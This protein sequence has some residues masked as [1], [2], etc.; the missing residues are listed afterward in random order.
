MI[1]YIIYELSN[2][3][4]SQKEQLLYNLKSE[5]EDVCCKK[6][7]IVKLYIIDNFSK[8]YKILRYALWIR[9]CTTRIEFVVKETFPIF[10]NHGFVSLR[11]KEMI[12]L[13]IFEDNIGTVDH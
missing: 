4:L 1:I 7:K 5:V 3:W 13:D 9:D 6:W 10:S 8:M 2:H 12:S 11:K